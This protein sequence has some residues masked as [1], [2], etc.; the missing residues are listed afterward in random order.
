ML[1]IDFAQLPDTVRQAV[2]NLTGPIRSTQTRSSDGLSA[3][4]AV[5]HTQSGTYLVKG[6]PLDQPEAHAQQLEVRLNP[7]LPASC[8]RLVWHVEVGGWTLLGYEAIQGRQADYKAPEDLRL[9]LA[10]MEELQG[11]QAP[12]I[13]DLQ[14]V[15]D[16]WGQ[17]ADDGQ[18]RLFAGNAL[19]RMDWAPDNVLIA[20]GRAHLV[21]WAWA[22]RGAGWIDPYMLALRLLE[23]GHTSKQAVDYVRRVR[24]WREGN[25]AAIRAFSAAAARAWYD[26]ASEEPVSWKVDMTGHAAEL[27]AFLTLESGT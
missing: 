6:T 19:L 14:T 17:Y 27:R 24:S 10:A 5:L 7:Y 16:R 18:R 26:I 9:V 11:I 3:L 12:L 13:A 8:P 23:A 21:H 25:P 22:T 20:D 15:P 2:A 1:R 4:A